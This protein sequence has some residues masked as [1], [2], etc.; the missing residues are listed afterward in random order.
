M[1][2]TGILVCLLYSWG[3]LETYSAYLGQTP[4]FYWYQAYAHLFFTARNGLFYTPIFIYAGYYLSECYETKMFSSRPLFKLTLTFVLLCL[5][6]VLVHANQGIDKN[7]MLMMPL[8][9]IFLFNAYTRVSWLRQYN[10]QR[11]KIYSVYYYFLHPI[12]IELAL[13]FLKN[14][15]MSYHDRGKLLFLSALVGSHLTTELILRYRKKG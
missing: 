15:S 13:F 14:S 8:F 2:K 6:G 7:F 1:K 4:V 3:M 5:E 10:L 9:S 11:F 12:F